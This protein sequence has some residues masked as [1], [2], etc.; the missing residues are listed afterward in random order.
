MVINSLGNATSLAASRNL[1]NTRSQLT[2]AFEKLSSGVR[3]NS[4]ADD[5]AALA[6]STALKTQLQGISQASR[7]AADAANLVMTADQGLSDVTGALNR[8][9]E[10]AVQGNSS[11]LAAE[12]RSALQKEVAQL[13]DSIAQATNT[14]TFNGRKLLDGSFQNVRMQVG[15]NPGDELDL[16]IGGVSTP[17][18]DLTSVESAADSLT[19]IDASL[20]SISDQRADLGA[21]SNRLGMAMSNLATLAENTRA[22]DTRI[23]DVDVAAESAALARQNV[24]SMGGVAILTQANTA[25]Q[26]ALRLLR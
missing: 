10:L 18:V 6:V 21:T 4:A 26:V 5:A 24:L 16:S 25:S 15:V 3:V 2:K 19:A 8:L 9:R 23:T 13:Q 11:L 17:D 7:S 20:E 1:N 22:S 12:D 14:V